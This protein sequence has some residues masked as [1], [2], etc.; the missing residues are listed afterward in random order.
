MKSTALTIS[1]VRFKSVNTNVTKLNNYFQL[2]IAFT[3]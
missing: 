3:V 1:L 2:K